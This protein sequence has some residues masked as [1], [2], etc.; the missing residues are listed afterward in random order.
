ME[1]TRLVFPR[2]VM[3]AVTVA[4]ALGTILALGAKPAGSATV[5]ASGQAAHSVRATNRAW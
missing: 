1:C 2:L 5:L 3:A 4:A